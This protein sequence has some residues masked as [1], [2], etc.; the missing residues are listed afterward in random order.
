MEK[1]KGYYSASLIAKWFLFYNDTL[2]ERED[3]D[4]ISN[5][6]LQKL[7]YYA[8]GC[9]LALKD[10]PLFYERIVNWMHGPVVEEVYYEYRKYGSKGIEYQGDYDGSISEETVA[11]LEE[12]FRVFGK[13]SAW[14][15]RN[16]THEED[17][18]KNTC[19]NQVISNESI[20]EY[21]Q[22]N[23]IEK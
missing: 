15:L 20:K 17:P 2:L 14:G 7:L 5:L 1:Q 4:L 21:F 18:W 9:Y 8:Q 11:V 6:K 10:E 13:Y 3:S 16:M 19:Q 23:Y 12:V 22:K